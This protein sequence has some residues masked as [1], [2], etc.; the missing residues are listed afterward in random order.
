MKIWM[1]ML[2]LGVGTFLIRYSLIGLMG[3]IHIPPRIER[4]FR[5]IPASMLSALV[6][7]QLASYARSSVSPLTN[8]YYLAALVACGVAWKTRNTLLV[9]FMGMIVLWVLRSI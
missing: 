8:P 7:S 9:V 4:A 1:I 3:K 2:A 6:V 5:F